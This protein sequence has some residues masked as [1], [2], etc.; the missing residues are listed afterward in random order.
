M[1]GQAED[2]ELENIGREETS[3]QVL[4][5]VVMEESARRKANGEPTI[6]DE[7]E[8]ADRARAGKL[9]H[10]EENGNASAESGGWGGKKGSG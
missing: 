5:E 7:L 3:T 10:S 9:S 1:G 4:Q 2:E 8:Q 6:V